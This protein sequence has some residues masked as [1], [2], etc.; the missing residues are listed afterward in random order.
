MT[1][2]AYESQLA[3]INDGVIEVEQIQLAT[4]KL[5]ADW[6]IP[7]SYYISVDVDETSALIFI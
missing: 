5:N 4:Q 7:I 2:N 3:S 1:I 6:P